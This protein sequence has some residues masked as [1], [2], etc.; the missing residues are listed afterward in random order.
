MTNHR[1]FDNAGISDA[2]LSR[3]GRARAPIGALYVIMR[4]VA[5]AFDRWRAGI[6]SHRARMATL[7]MSDHTLRDIGLTRHEILM[8]H[9]RGRM[10]PQKS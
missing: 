10:P 9:A 3:P 4:P 2:A 7:S 6:R 1:N 5:F 8:R